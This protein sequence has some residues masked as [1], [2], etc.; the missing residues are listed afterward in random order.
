[1]T[2][3][4]HLL[5]PSCRD[6]KATCCFLLAPL[7]CCPL[8][9]NGQAPAAKKAV[10][11][12]AK[13][14]LREG[15]DIA[16]IASRSKFPA[17]SALTLEMRLLSAGKEISLLEREAAAS[18]L[19]R[20][21]EYLSILK[22]LKKQNPEIFK[23]QSLRALGIT[24][25]LFREAIVQER[26]IS[27]VSAPIKLGPISRVRTIAV[28]PQDEVTFAKVFEAEITLANKRS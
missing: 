23:T 27:T 18:Q 26:L 6:M 17:K 9:S 25:K 8:P 13:Q 21:E 12:V 20:Q 14:F 2:M 7:I 3:K 28:I 16:T 15:D 4:N 24:E 22:N 11:I 10:E 19:I 1:M 5:K